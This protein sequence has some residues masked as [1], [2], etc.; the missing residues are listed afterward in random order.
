MTGGKVEEKVSWADLHEEEEREGKLEEVWIEVVSG[1]KKKVE[2][3]RK[4]VEEETRRAAEEVRK[5]YRWLRRRSEE[6]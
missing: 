3:V 6:K 1:W 5:P 2:E 4:K